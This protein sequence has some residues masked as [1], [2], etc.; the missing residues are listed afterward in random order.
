MVA[1]LTGLLLTEESGVACPVLVLR[2]RVIEVLCSD[3]EGGKEDA[4]SC[5]R[6]A[7]GGRGKTRSQALKVD[8]GGEKGGDLNIGLLHKDGDESFKR[9]KSRVDREGLEVLL[10]G[11]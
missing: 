5:A 10:V 8:E 2:R 6:H 9:R 7:L 1:K 3:N 4:V 11:R